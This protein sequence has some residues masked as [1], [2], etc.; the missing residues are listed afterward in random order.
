M[1]SAAF[2]KEIT[3]L[4]V[5][6]SIKD[7]EI[8]CSFLRSLFKEVIEA[9]D[10][11][12]GLDLYLK[13][14]DKINVIISDINMPLMNGLDMLKEIRSDNKLVP[15]IFITGRTEPE[16]IIEAINENANF[17]ILKPI[18]TKILLE[19]ILIIC[20][21]IYYETRL[22]QKQEEV[23][24][25]LEA[26]DNVA[27]IYKMY[28][29][30]NIT[31]MN[32]S[33]LDISKFSTSDIKNL[34]FSDII[35]PSIP[36]EYI[37]QTWEELKEGKTWKGNTKFLDKSKEIFYLNSTIFKIH[38]SSKEDAYISISFLTTQDNLKKRDFHKKVIQNIQ[39]FNKKEHELKMH[40]L[41]LEKT[42]SDLQEILDTCSQKLEKEKRK[43]LSK[44]RQIEHFESQMQALM[45]KHDAV[46]KN[47]QQETQ[48]QINQI[49]EANKKIDKLY[50]EKQTLKKEVE[51]LK[52]EVNK[53]ENINQQ[54]EQKIRNL[55]DVL[56]L[57]EGYKNLK[58]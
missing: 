34:N 4:V 21:K 22:Q 51:V 48:G 10:G 28:G 53:L 49:N 37:E 54:R 38:E 13:H 45:E 40:V 24:K 2:L 3:L 41:K 47:K 31:Y 36:K 50:Y 18:D 30:G 43:T 17:Y 57:E 6:D 55:Q 29:D 39:D 46:L 14:K 12:E 42:S 33:M 20:E 15:L 9:S 58:K 16:Y 8:L 23:A 27:L 32:K 5:E 11:I 19:K 56:K 52:Q 44:D 25:Y 1:F 35:H 26:V 7:R